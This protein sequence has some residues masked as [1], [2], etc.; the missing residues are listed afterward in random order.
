MRILT[1]A[2]VDGLASSVLLTLVEHITGIDLA[3]PK[4]VQ[5]GKVPVTPEHIIVNLPYHPDCGLWF[6]HHVSEQAK[7]KD[8]GRFRGAFRGAPSCARIIYEHY[9]SPKFEPHADMVDATDRLDSAQLTLEDITHPQDFILLGLTIDPR[10]ASGP[11]FERYFRWLVE[12]IKEL[13]LD[14]VL[15][16]RE[17]KRRCDRVLQEQEAFKDILRQRSRVDGNVVISDLRGVE[18]LPAGNRFLVFTLYPQAEVEVRLFEGPDDRVVL[19][20]G[21]NIFNRT[22]KVSCGELLARYGGGGHFG[23]GTCQVPADRIDRVLAEVVE[24]FR[25]NEPL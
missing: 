10:T 6:D 12:Y 4:D 8:I 9:Q 13:P 15:Q 20:A 1:R 25:K 3:H 5:D 16:H 24:V 7:L 22:S 18:R 21:H 2:D 14:K 17:V 23:A 11:D 19:A